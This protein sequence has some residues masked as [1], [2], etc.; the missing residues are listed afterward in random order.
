MQAKKIFSFFLFLGILCGSFT[1]KAQNP[2]YGICLLEFE[3]VRGKTSDSSE[4]VTQL[5]FGDAFKILK[6]SEDAAWVFIENAYD[7]YQGWIRIRASFQISAAYYEEYL[8]NS[9]PVAHDSKAQV[10]IGKQKIAVPMGSTLPFLDQEGYI[11]IEQTKYKFSGRT[12]NPAE[13]TDKSA[14]IQTA[15]TYLGTPYLWGGKSQKGLDC[16]G[17]TQTVFKTHGLKI[18]RDSYQQAEQGESIKFEEAQPGDLLFFQKTP[19]DFVKVT[20]VGIYLGEGKLIHAFDQ[21]E[22]DQVDEKGIYRDGKY[23]RY[24]KLI[25]RY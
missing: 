9:H 14:L 10:L 7:N 15:K 6:K 20:H 25:K 2:E 17:F 4:Q 13:K 5:L 11:R 21:V 8:R 12:R 24:L 22:I 16:S 1:L 23:L 18:L 3:A 19:G